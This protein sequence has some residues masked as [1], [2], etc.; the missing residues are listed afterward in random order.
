MKASVATTAGLS[1]QRSH[2]EGSLHPNM[3]FFLPTGRQNDKMIA[4]FILNY[5]NKKGPNQVLKLEILDLETL[6]LYIID[7]NWLRV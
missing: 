4:N 3:R 2:I 5:N 6:S 7:T 1:A